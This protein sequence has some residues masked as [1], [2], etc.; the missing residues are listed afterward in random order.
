MSTEKIKSTIIWI[1][2]ILIILALLFGAMLVIDKASNIKNGE[3]GYDSLSVQERRLLPVD[4][5]DY[6]RGNK[7]AQITVIEYSDF[8]CPACVAYAPVVRDLLLGYG[9]EVRFVSRSFPLPQHRLARVASYAAEAAG[10]Q[11]KFYEMSDVLNEKK[12]EWNLENDPT[13]NFKG[14]AV[15][16][17]LDV[18]KF[19]ADMESEIVKN[20][21]DRDER[22]AYELQ[23]FATPS[24]FVDGKFVSGIEEMKVL[25]DQKTQK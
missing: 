25:L 8:E 2:A 10:L 6:I 18:S 22:N 4:E 7:E 1:V 15:S 14:Y 13:N 16:L 12:D 23:L 3:G 24:F 9:D 20:K 11:G 19:E 5:S 21:V 17:G